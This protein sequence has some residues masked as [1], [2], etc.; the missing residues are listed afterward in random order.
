MR[1]IRIVAMDDGQLL[2]RKKAKLHVT[3]DDVLEYAESVIGS[4][5]ADYVRVYID[6]KLYAEFEN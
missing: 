6:E 1:T 3:I 2:F 5:Y 4:R